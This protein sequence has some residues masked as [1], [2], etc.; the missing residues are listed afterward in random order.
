M[1][2]EIC[3]LQWQFGR[4]ERTSK[5]SPATSHRCHSS[6]ANGYSAAAENAGLRGRALLGLFGAS[7]FHLK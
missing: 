6:R 4:T 1:V 2:V 3:L 5:M 7:G